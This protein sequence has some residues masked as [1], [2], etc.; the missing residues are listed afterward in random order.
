MTFAAAGTGHSANDMRRTV[1][2]AP[3]RLNPPPVRADPWARPE[4]IRADPASLPCGG[5]S[6]TMSS[7]DYR[8]DTACRSA[9]GNT[10]PSPSMSADGWI[11][12]NRQAPAWRQW[13]TREV[14]IIREHYPSGGVDACAPLM[15]HPR[16][17][18]AIHAKARALGV[19]C[20]RPPTKGLRLPRLYVA[21]PEVDQAIREAYCSARRK[22][23]V[24]ARTEHLGLPLWWVHK[25]AVELGASRNILARIDRWT[26]REMDMLRL[27]A[28]CGLKIIAREVSR[29]GQGR[30]PTACAVMLKRLHVDRADPDAWSGDSL[31]KLL[32][33]AGK[34]VH[35]WIER[36]GLPAAKV[37]ESLGERYRY[38][39]RRRPLRDW[40][41]KH[42]LL[43]DLRK[44]DQEWFMALAFGDD[45]KARELGHRMAA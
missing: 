9:C 43:I 41:A 29:V 45:T 4:P 16:T 7:T 38:S 8:I 12:G 28:P 27:Y 23:D 11:R 1:C 2:H 14:A 44:V 32:G 17:R 15:T 20:S 24:K 37:A 26:E 25:R 22:G 31:A 13:T 18:S 40:I 21:T 30:T 10:E 39:I 3:P 19:K 6:R 33:V 35:D 36:R 42:P 34:T 5:L